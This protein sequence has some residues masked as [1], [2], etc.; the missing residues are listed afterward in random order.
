MDGFAVLDALKAN[1]ETAYIPVIV[2][3]AK[4]LTAEEKKDPFLKGFKENEMIFHWHG[5]MFQIP[6]DGQLLATGTGCPHQA[7][8]VGKNA[9][10]IQFHVEITDVSIKEWCAEYCQKDSSER[11]KKSEELIHGY[12]QHKKQFNQQ[13]ERLYENFLNI[14]KAQ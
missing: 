14:L 9:Y 3:T 4:E 2:S 8:R 1:P 6:G 13:A 11:V 5:D 7:I 12:S 10:G